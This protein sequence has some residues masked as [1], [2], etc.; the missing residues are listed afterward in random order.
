MEL[1]YAIV[2]IVLVARAFA[3]LLGINGAANSTA[4]IMAT[5]VL[6]PHLAVI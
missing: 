2:L 6:P 4:T 3:F 5:H 1:P